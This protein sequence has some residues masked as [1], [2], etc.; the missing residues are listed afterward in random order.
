MYYVEYRD[1][2]TRETKIFD[3]YA[4]SE[5]E[6]LGLFCIKNPDSCYNDVIDIYAEDMVF[7]NTKKEK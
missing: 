4:F 7:L 1:V 6:A 3:T 2:I 5:E